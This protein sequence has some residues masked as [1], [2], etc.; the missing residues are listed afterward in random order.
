[1]KRKDVLRVVRVVKTVLKREVVAVLVKLAGET[2]KDK[3]FRAALVGLGT[4]AA[5]YFGIGDVAGE[6]LKG[7]AE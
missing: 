7:I 5:N 4:I 1:M 2:V 6:V 3:V